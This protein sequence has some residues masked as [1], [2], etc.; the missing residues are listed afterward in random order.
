MRPVLRRRPV[1][2]PPLPPSRRSCRRWSRRWSPVPGP[3]PA[4]GESPTVRAVGDHRPARLRRGRR[5]TRGST[6]AR[7]RTPGHPSRRRRRNPS[8]RLAARPRPRRVGHRACRRGCS[9]PTG[10][11]RGRPGRRTRRCRWTG[12]CW[13]GIGKVESGHA[14]GGAVDRHGRHPGAHPRAGAGRR[15][16]RRGDP[17]HRRRPVGRRHAPGTARWGRCSS[18]RRR[19]G[20]TAPTATATASRDP[21]NVARRERSRSARLPVHG[22]AAT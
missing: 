11:P 6:G 16:G 15:P 18:S 7:G 14:Y 20:S 4:G 21:N 10:R 3:V 2:R 19:G 22:R 8:G 9:P 1:P 5:A 12:R 17:R 13:P